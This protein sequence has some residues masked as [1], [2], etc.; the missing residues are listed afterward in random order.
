MA[1]LAL[2][3]PVINSHAA[4]RSRGPLC[5]KR[6]PVQTGESAALT[7]PANPGEVADIGVTV[8]ADSRPPGVIP[9]CTDDAL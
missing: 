2:S 6:R 7:A 8:A 1:H 9:I 5:P 3:R 4:M